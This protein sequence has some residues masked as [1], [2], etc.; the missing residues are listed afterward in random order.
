[1][2]VVVGLLWRTFA[3]LLCG[4]YGEREKVVLCVYL[5]KEAV[6]RGLY[7]S[8]KVR[9]LEESRGWFCVCVTLQARTRFTSTI[10]CG[11]L[12]GLNEKTC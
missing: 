9:C 4:C 7:V 1:V 3:T 10:S 11:K 2:C 8:R 12:G 6:A 5:C